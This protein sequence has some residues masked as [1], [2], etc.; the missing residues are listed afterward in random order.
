MRTK[1]ELIVLVLLGVMSWCGEVAAR[2]WTSADGRALEAEFLS[3]TDRHVTLR[4]E[5][6]GKRFTLALDK[7]SETDRKWIAEKL[8]EKAGLEP[9][10]ATGLFEGR[11]TEEWEKMEYASLQ[12]RFYGGKGLSKKARYPVVVFLHGKGSGGTD[13]EK[14]LGGSP[15]KFAEEDFYK[16]NPSFII[17]PQCPD[18][19]KGWNGEYRDDV[20]ALVKAAVEHLPVDENRL[21]ITGLSMGGFG[22]FSAIAAAPD[23]FA[24]AVPVC[25]GGNPGSAKDIKDI[26]IW[27]HHGEADPTV[28]VE[29]SRRMVKALEEEKG[30]VKYTE[31]D[32]ASGIMHN[33]WTPC[34]NN[35]EVL[36]WMFA[37]SKG[38][39]AEEADGAK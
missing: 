4:R 3:A 20:I 36:E 25:G 10:E 33:A 18:D 26:A 11:L 32:V 14:Q 23:L 17:V 16:D 38:K 21:Y 12:F 7:I 19:S 6:D 1:N 9:K 8:A 37:Q 15:K 2:T 13:N 28:K 34:Y 27:V 29:A 5:A 22:T 39:K 24:A 31:Y 30:N 35:P